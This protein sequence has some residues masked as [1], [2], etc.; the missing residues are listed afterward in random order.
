MVEHTFWFGRV[1]SE[2]GVFHG[3]SIWEREMEEIFSRD[4]KSTELLGNEGKDGQ[5]P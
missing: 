5:Y 2:R 1:G 3:S 4:Q